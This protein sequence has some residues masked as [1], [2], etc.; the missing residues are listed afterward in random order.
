MYICRHNCKL[1]I[2]TM[3]Y[4]LDLSG[5]GV[6]FSNINQGV[7]VDDSFTML[8]VIVMLL[9][10]TVLYAMVAWYVE[11]V[12]P[13]EYGVP[14]RWYFPVMVSD[15]LSPANG[16][17]ISLKRTNTIFTIHI[18]LFMLRRDQELS[19]QS[20]MDKAVNQGHLFLPTLNVSNF[21]LDRL[22]LERKL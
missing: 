19:S 4:N 21:R 18:T 10:D 20:E 3:F 6:Q 7:S 22:I 8:H 16:K 1:Q 2:A 11:A 14:Y 15:N 5:A 12:W 17:F 13:G 9:V